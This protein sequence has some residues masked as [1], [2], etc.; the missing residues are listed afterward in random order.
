MNKEELPEVLR[1]M[2]VG[3]DEVDALARETLHVVRRMLERPRKQ[4]DAGLLVL[5]RE[6][7]PPPELVPIVL[8]GWDTDQEKVQRYQAAGAGFAGTGKVPVAA[9]IF[10]E[11][12]MVERPL[13]DYLHG[14]PGPRPR[15][16]PARQEVIVIGA[17]ALGE[18]EQG[19][20]SLVHT[21]VGTLRF[22]RDRRK[23]L[24][25]GKFE[26]FEESAKDF[27]LGHFF[28]GYAAALIQMHDLERN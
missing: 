17:G 2:L 22:S 7:Q 24:V 8:S 11:A 25:A 14:Y 20:P 4:L 27:L 10:N 23:R 6:G 15:D 3:R 26:G 16:H 19:R 12:W 1:G 28:V 21:V 13:E 18:D 5:A 9:A